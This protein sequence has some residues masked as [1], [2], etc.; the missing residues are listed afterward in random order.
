MTNGFE[1][2]KAQR[3]LLERL[4]EK[5]PGF[6]GFRDRELRRDVDKM[7]R[8]HIAG[9]LT[10]LKGRVRELAGDYTDAGQI[11]VLD[12]FEKLDRRL[13]R[14]ARS[15]QHADYGTTGIFDPEKIGE[16]ELERLYAFDLTLLDDL[17]AL[18][19]G[20]EDLPAPGGEG[21]P[22]GVLEDLLARVRTTEEKWGTREQVM[23]NVV[24]SAGLPGEE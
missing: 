13:E 19:R 2:A 6:R 7:Q 23:T 24:E 4:G 11:G 3:N 21:D 9:E 10:D 16:A 18:E 22:E 14:L 1:D 8:Q 20:V 15:V 5:I 17:A 12:R